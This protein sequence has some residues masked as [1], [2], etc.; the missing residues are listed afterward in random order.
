LMSGSSVRRRWKRSACTSPLR[1][2]WQMRCRQNDRHRSPMPAWLAPVRLARED[3]V[4][5][6]RKLVELALDVAP[7]TEDR[8]QSLPDFVEYVAPLRRQR[9]RDR[10]R[11][12]RF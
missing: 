12:L 5:L 8:A 4:D 7:I 11:L 6:R 1:R 2:D 10:L 9:E 3:G